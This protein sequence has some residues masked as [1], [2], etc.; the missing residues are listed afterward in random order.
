MRTES[1][2]CQPVALC[3]AVTRMDLLAFWSSGPE[4][5]RHLQLHDRQYSQAIYGHGA[6]GGDD[7]SWFLS[8]LCKLSGLTCER[9]T[10][11]ID[12]VP[13]GNAR[14][15]NMKSYSEH[16]FCRSV[17]QPSIKGWCTGQTSEAVPGWDQPPKRVRQ[18]AVAVCPSGTL[19]R[20]RTSVSSPG[21]CICSMCLSNQ[22]ARGSFLL[23]TSAELECEKVTNGIEQ[24]KRFKKCFIVYLESHSY[25]VLL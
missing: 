14:F 5:P 6:R 22:E 21:M 1:C 13:G 10:A 2:T 9:W 15:S 11:H 8:S 16:Y 17:Q 23:Q 24:K 4:V 3:C 20:S 25:S 18:G 12:E 19:H 7:V